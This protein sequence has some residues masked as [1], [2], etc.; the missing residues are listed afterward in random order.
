MLLFITLDI[1]LSYAT[2][3]RVT[4]RDDENKIDYFIFSARHVPLVITTSS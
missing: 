4:F 2:M 1:L 3:P